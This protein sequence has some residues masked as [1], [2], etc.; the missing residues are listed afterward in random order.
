MV[1]ATV[2]DAD[3]GETT[4]VKDTLVEAAEQ[5][6]TVLPKAG[7][8]QEVVLDKGYHSTQ[9]LRRDRFHGV[10]SNLFCDSTAVTRIWN[11]SYM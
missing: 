7:N 5:V 3:V 4:T 2:Q 11:E 1:D 8:V 9:L 10:V 6:E